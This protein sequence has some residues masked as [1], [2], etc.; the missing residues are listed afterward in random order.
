MKK[1]DKE[2]SNEGLSTFKTMLDYIQ[3]HY[4]EKITL[5]GLCA[6]AGVN[7]NKCAALFKQY[8][9]MSPI[10]YVRYYRIDKSVPL[11]RKTDLSITEIAYKVGFSGPSF[12]TETFRQQTGKSPT[13]VRQSMEM[14]MP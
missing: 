10:E 4:E 9:N 1:A 11:L 12:F 8:T 13:Q 14:R 3:L 7:K 2:S 5:H 6:C